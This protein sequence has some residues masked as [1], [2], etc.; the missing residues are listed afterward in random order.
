M[1]KKKFN[2]CSKCNF[3]HAS[4]TGKGC[5]AGDGEQ[6]LDKPM[7]DETIQGGQ[8]SSRVGLD[9]RCDSPNRRKAG[10]SHERMEKI[11]L[12]VTAMGD[13]LDLIVANMKKPTVDV[14]EEEE[15][16]G[17]WTKDIA[18]AWSEVKDRSRQKHK[19]AKPLKPRT[20]RQKSNS[21]SDSSSSDAYISRLSRKDRGEYTPANTENTDH[22]RSVCPSSRDVTASGST[23]DVASQQAEQADY[24]GE[25]AENIRY[26]KGFNSN[27]TSEAVEES[28]GDTADRTE[29]F[30]KVLIGQETDVNVNVLNPVVH[31]FTLEEG[32]IVNVYDS[33]R[34]GTCSCDYQ[35]SGEKL[36]LKPCR[37]A[38]LVSLGTAECKKAYEPLV[39]N[40]TDGF[41]IVSDKL[42]WELFYVR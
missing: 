38:Y 22:G 10:S 40:V 6:A 36:Q 35:L 33:C 11:E 19:P 25:K 34:M 26:L 32:A 14:L 12:D 29:I 42:K 30:S 5:L 3:R 18:D 4:P 21:S 23:Q 7:E 9:G 24:G 28:C 2:L 8:A 20:R 1:G 13:K 15:V 31:T 39:S 16:V 27:Y 37:F 17:D 41:R